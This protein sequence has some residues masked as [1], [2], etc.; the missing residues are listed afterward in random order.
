MINTANKLNKINPILKQKIFVKLKRIAKLENIHIFALP[1]KI[2][3]KDIMAMFKG[4]LGLMR[5]KA[6]Q[7]Q[8][9]K[10]LML[11]LK[12]DR[13]KYLYNKLKSNQQTIV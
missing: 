11:K 1:T 12:Y 5:E 4:V 3:D 6:Q 2:Q 10:F 8:T 13:L 9:E 7:E